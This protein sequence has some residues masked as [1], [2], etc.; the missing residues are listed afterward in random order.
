MKKLLTLVTVVL[1]SVA[2]AACGNSS[3]EKSKGSDEKVIKVG[4]TGQSFP[5]AYQEDG[6]LVGYDVEV[7]NTIA[8]NLGYK[9]E[10]TT[11]DFSGLMGQLNSGRID[12]VANAVAVTAEREKMYKFTD[13]YSYIGTQIVTSK[14]NKNV[15]QIKDLKGKTVAGVLGSNHVEKLQ[16]YNTK[17]KM[18]LNIKTYETREG[19]MN[20][21]EL[22]RIDGYVN[23]GSVLSAEINKHDFKA[24]L[25]GKPIDE[26]ATAFPFQKDNDELREK[27]NTELKKLKEDGTLEKLSQKYFGTNTVESQTK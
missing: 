1:L 5:N 3:D 7:M 16:E 22:G 23:S 11:T 14:D 18:N 20:D 19:A 9:V 8:K 26:D 12:T 15:N 10:W 6:K 13:P 27:V 4:A 25:V 17:N 2:L 24:K 21:V